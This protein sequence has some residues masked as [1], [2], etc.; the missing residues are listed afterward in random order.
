MADTSPSFLSLMAQVTTAHFSSLQAVSLS[1]HETQKQ[2]DKTRHDLTTEKSEFARFRTDAA[3][4]TSFLETQLASTQKKL[5]VA[6]QRLRDASSKDKDSSRETKDSPRESSKEPSREDHDLARDNQRLRIRIA[7]LNHLREV[8]ARSFRDIV[9]D[10]DK[11]IE[12]L[13]SS[14]LIHTNNALS[15]HTNTSLSHNKRSLVPFDPDETQMPTSSQMPKRLKPSSPLKSRTSPNRAMSENHPASAI[16]PAALDQ[17]PIE[18]ENSRP[19]IV[20]P[21]D[22]ERVDPLKHHDKDESEPESAA[23]QTPLVEN[24][25]LDNHNSNDEEMDEHDSPPPPIQLPGFQNDPPP[26]QTPT[27]SSPSNPRVQSTT[28]TPFKTPLPVANK[29]TAQTTPTPTTLN[30]TTKSNHRSAAT[31]S[32]SAAATASVRGVASSS[33]SASKRPAVPEPKYQD[34]VRGKEE[35]R[36]LH[37]TSCACCSD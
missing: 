29:P 24:M 10:K 31:P 20:A 12:A 1:H 6:V 34:V 18:I 15:N 27:K 25:H 9:H 37:G 33:G 13:H 4:Q 3:L 19:L 7:E 36:K 2:L 30:T 35:R 16:H 22:R 28:T 14:L 32:S 5:L 26:K 17:H 23:S 11:E 21:E 8:E